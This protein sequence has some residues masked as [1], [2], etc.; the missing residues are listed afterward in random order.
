MMILDNPQVETG[1]AALGFIGNTPLLRIRRFEE[2]HPG[3]ELYAKAEWF[4]IGGSVK[5]RPALRIIED[6]ER[7]GRLTPEKTLID[8]TSGNTGIAYALICAVK[9]Y[10]CELVMP[11]NVSQERKRTISSY[12][13]KITYT[14]PFEGSDGAIRYVR[15]VVAAQ[16]EKYFYA[17]QYNNASNWKAHYDSTGPEI[18]EQTQ[19][20]ITHFVA[21]LG[22]S[23]TLMGVGRR[24]REYNP[25]I[26]LIGVQPDDP[27]N[28]LEGL[29]HMETAI[30]PGIYDE[31]LLDR[32]LGISTEA[33]Y[34]TAR[35]LAR[36]EGLFAG[37]SSGAALRG[38]LDIAAETDKAVI[39]VLLPDG[40]A[41]YLSTSLWQLPQT[42]PD[43]TAQ[44]S[45]L[46]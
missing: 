44:D 40:G 10:K 37:Q 14:D 42:N 46:W 17:D 26:Q 6:A 3:I 28:G 35:D 30:R 27:F 36:R 12:G 32:K 43:A 31:D 41:R 1:S 15:A 38:A 21:G 22:T 39:V 9:G 34:S 16:P 29:K 8:S 24:L 45:T 11:E 23:G 4:N 13:A 2:L 33:G 5:D 25:G 20:R 19:G 7:D 18:W